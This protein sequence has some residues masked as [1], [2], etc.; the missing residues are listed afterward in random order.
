M[1]SAA[2]F[3]PFLTAL[4]NSGLLSDVVTFPDDTYN[5]KYGVENS[6][7]AAEIAK[8]WPGGVYFKKMPSSYFA[9]NKYFPFDRQLV[10]SC[11][12]DAE[13]CSVDVL[14]FSFPANPQKMGASFFAAQFADIINDLEQFLSVPVFA[15]DF[16]KV[17]EDS[18]VK[19]CKQNQWAF[20]FD[21]KTTA[22]GIHIHIRHFEVSCNPLTERVNLKTGEYD[23][24][25]PKNVICEDCRRPSPPVYVEAF[26]PDEI[27]KNRILF[28]KT[29]DLM[30]S[31]R[32][33]WNAVR[34]K[35]KTIVE[36]KI[37][38]K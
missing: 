27:K 7:K 2:A 12:P 21:S 25:R 32:A 30:A 11:R 18:I 6:K 26:P 14:Y 24:P 1:I 38:K 22:D 28:K 10:I 20:V 17:C 35:K 33:A 16:P 9:I 36:V 31:R 19:Y 4:L 37:E 8:L 23:C 29:M 15:H 34:S 3:L 13:R 5:N